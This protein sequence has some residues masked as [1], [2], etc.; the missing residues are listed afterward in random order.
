MGTVTAKLAPKVL[1]LALAVLG[2]RRFIAV[3]GAISGDTEKAT[4]SDGLTLRS[5]TAMTNPGGFLARC[6]PVWR[7]LS[8]RVRWVPEVKTAGQAKNQYYP[9]HWVVEKGAKALKNLTKVQ[10]EEIIDT[11]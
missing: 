3:S 1:N 5:R 2:I 8:Q 7:H 4:S 10:I 11:R 6:W 9:A